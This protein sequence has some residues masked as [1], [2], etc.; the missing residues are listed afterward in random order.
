MKVLRSLLAGLCLAV[1]LLAEDDAPWLV[2][3]ARL[4]SPWL[5]AP[6]S[7]TRL[8]ASD[9]Q[10][11]PGLDLGRLLEGRSGAAYAVKG[12]GFA[13]SKSGVQMRGW[14]LGSELVLVLDGRRLSND[15]DGEGFDLSL[16]DLSGLEAV[17]LLRGSASSLYGSGAH[18]GVIQLVSR[19]GQAMAGSHLNVLGGSFGYERMGF[20]SQLSQNNWSLSLGLTQEGS[21]DYATPDQG[22]WLNSSWQRLLGH[23]RLDRELGPQAGLSLKLFFA[24]GQDNGL[25]GD[26]AAPAPD[27]KDRLDDRV[28][29]ALEFHRAWGPGHLRLVLDES[30]K[31]RDNLRF[32]PR[33]L[34]RT[35]VGQLQMSRS[36]AS[37]LAY[38]FQSGQQRI[39]VGAELRVEQHEGSGWIQPPSA[40]GFSAP[41]LP[42][43]Q[44]QVYAAYLQDEW[45]PWER[46]HLSLGLRHDSEGR[47]LFSDASSMYGSQRRDSGEASGH[48]GASYQL[49]PGLSLKTGWAL[50]RVEPNIIQLYTFNP[51]T[52]F[53]LLGNPK[54][55]A[56]RGYTLEAGLAGEKGN[57]RFELTGFHSEM[58]GRLVLG[59]L[60]RDFANGGNSFLDLNKAYARPDL[61]A[62]PRLVAAPTNK[63]FY[64]YNLGLTLTE[65]LE[66]MA[67]YNPG[68]WR[69][70]ASCSAMTRMIE[71]SQSRWLDSLT[72]FSTRLSLGRRSGRLQGQVAWR[73]G[74]GYLTQSRTRPGSPWVDKSGYQVTDLDL[75]VECWQGGRITLSL[76]NIFDQA[77][78]QTLDVPEAGRQWRLGLQQRI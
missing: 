48:A 3:A 38:D 28:Y 15:T 60:L 18:A 44:V 4:N 23:A 20:S 26:L 72:P 51:R 22:T 9:L 63:W 47:E 31:A 21:R 55:D 68:S 54:L 64:H 49:I 11:S 69:F 75:N 46:L 45:Q 43:A 29:A 13:S 19:K 62:D 76:L 25:P 74:A 16:L 17:E 8:D 77:W 40:M 78:Q 41:K 71:M 52:G 7:I 32:G 42:P 27:D 65:G 1:N 73:Y 37:L 56:E 70:E 30:Y 10:A 24:R 66:A 57:W 61:L 6:Q 36:H 59:V 67:S 53:A 34:T 2:S 35:T 33:G 14:A 50:S 12:N 5:D 39:L 58:S